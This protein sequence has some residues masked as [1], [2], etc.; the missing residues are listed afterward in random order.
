MLM[1]LLLGLVFFFIGTTKGFTDICSKYNTVPKFNTM[2]SSRE[3]KQ[4]FTPSHCYLPVAD[5]EL[6][7]GLSDP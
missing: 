7:Y 2:F 1:V 6:C 3:C 4:D 5:V